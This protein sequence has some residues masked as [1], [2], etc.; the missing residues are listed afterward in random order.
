MK[1]KVL[2]RYFV[3]Q[4]ELEA[5]DEEGVKRAFEESWDVGEDEVEPP[6][7]DVGV[8]NSA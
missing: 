8:L 5:Y 2:R 3:L 6:H 4:T 7:S 1:M